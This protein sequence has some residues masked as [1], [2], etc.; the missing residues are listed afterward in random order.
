MA[1]TQDEL[2]LSRSV[3]GVIPVTSRTIALALVVVA[4]SYLYIR[5][6][7]TKKACRPL[8]NALDGYRL[9]V[10]SHAAV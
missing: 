2:P 8:V 1:L 9:T 6:R 7:S 4:F 3:V 5:T 10:T